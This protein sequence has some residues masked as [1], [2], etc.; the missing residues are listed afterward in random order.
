MLI[1]IMT[2]FYSNFSIFRDEKY[3]FLYFQYADSY[4]NTALCLARN[5][6]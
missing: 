2:Y 3:K 1:Y 6:L 4:K 5:L